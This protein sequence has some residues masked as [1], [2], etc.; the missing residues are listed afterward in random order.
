LSPVYNFNNNFPPPTLNPNGLLSTHSPFFPRQSRHGGALPFSPWS[1]TENSA[2]PLVPFSPF[3]ASFV[4]APH[5]PTDFDRLRE[6]HE[7][8]GVLRHK[9]EKF[10]KRHAALTEELAAKK[11][12]LDRVGRA[13]AALDADAQRLRPQHRELEEQLQA[14]KLQKKQVQGELAAVMRVRRADQLAVNAAKQ[15]AAE[16]EKRLAASDQSLVNEKDAS[17]ANLKTETEKLEEA[18]EEEKERVMREAEE[19]AEKGW[20]DR[21]KELKGEVEKLKRERDGEIEGWKDKLVAVEKEKGAFHSSFSPFPT[22]HP[23][24]TYSLYPSRRRNP[25]IPRHF[26]PETARFGGGCRSLE[27]DNRDAQVGGSD[28]KEEDG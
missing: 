3:S 20:I 18:F 11:E 25:E 26:L 7:Q 21:I 13:A 10:G 6:A 16:L 8:N 4:A 28:G 2:G 22:L 19:K 17:A 14:E 24:E 23:F 12:D 9:L 15:R 27:Q 1:P 5:I